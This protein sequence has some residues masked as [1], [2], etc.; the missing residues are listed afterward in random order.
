LRNHSAFAQESMTVCEAM[1]IY[2]RD[3]DMGLE[4]GGGQGGREGGR[5]GGEHNYS[6]SST[7]SIEC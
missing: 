2:R 1:R 6:L 5:G 4:A 3:A 7:C